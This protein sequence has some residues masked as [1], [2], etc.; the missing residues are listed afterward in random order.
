[1]TFQIE[2]IRRYQIG[3]KPA[4]GRPHH[5]FEHS[6]NGFLITGYEDGSDWLVS[7]LGRS[8][9]GKIFR[10]RPTMAW[11]ISADRRDYHRL[12]LYILDL[13]TKSY[14]EVSGLSMSRAYDIVDYDGERLVLLCPRTA[15]QGDPT[16][17]LVVVDIASAQIA[18]RFL[19]KG[20]TH[21]FD[22]PIGHTPDGWLVLD[23]SLLGENNEHL[24]KHGIARIHPYTREMSFELFP[25]YADVLISPSGQ[26]VLK[27]G[28]LLRP[29][30]GLSTEPA[31]MAGFGEG[32]GIYERWI[33]VWAV[34]PLNHVCSLPFEWAN[35]SNAWQFP[36]RNQIFWQPDET[37]FWWIQQTSAIC[38]GLDGRSSPPMRLDTYRSICSALPGRI[39]ELALERETTVEVYRLDGS[40]SADLSHRDAPAPMV[41]TPSAA[42]LK[43]QRNAQAALT[44]IVKAKSELR[45]TLKTAQAAD[46]VSVIDAITAALDRGLAWFADD[47]IIKVSVN[48]AGVPYDEKHFFALVE[49]HGSAAVP[50]LTRLL[51]KCRMDADLQR[52]WSSELEDGQQAFGAAAKALGGIDAGAW[53]ELAK[54]EMCIDDWH[55]LYF[56]DEVVPHFIESHGWC[57]ESF[58]LTLADIVQIRGNLGDDF[59]YSWQRSGLAAAAQAAYAPEAFADFMIGIRDRMLSSPVGTFANFAARVAE[60]SPSTYG[61]HNYDRLFDQINGSLT[62]WEVHLFAQLQDRAGR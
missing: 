12:H 34:N 4:P 26:Y 55:E 56:R 41:V 19:L 47:G 8:T 45:F 14:A 51:A 48:I 54:Y 7:P 20:C 59:S 46:I 3:H 11:A 52:V 36:D 21:L 50:A 13:P 43:R 17:E 18:E 35:Y 49:K 39:A 9:W 29:E 28:K 40:P 60:G 58:A 25:G 61:W 38:V 10:D 2:Y 57:E 30:L 1:M 62:P 27:A 23:A 37:A 53:I 42:E 22:R 33:E 24:Y 15:E 31:A 32:S 44:K 6:N 16:R 5:F